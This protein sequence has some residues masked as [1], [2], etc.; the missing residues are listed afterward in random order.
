MAKEDMVYRA[1]IPIV[2]DDFANKSRHKINELVMDF[3]NSDIYV[4]RETGYVNITGKIKDEIKKIQDGSMVLHIVT[5][6]TIPP[7]KDRKPNHWYFVVTKSIDAGSGY[8]INDNYI[9]YGTV[10]NFSIDKNYILFGQNFI[11][12]GSIVKIRVEENYVPCFYVPITYD[13]EYTNIDTEEKLDST[14]QGRVYALQN[15]SYTVYDVYTLDIRT[16]G[17]YN[18]RVSAVENDVYT[19]SF[20]A[21]IAA[22]GVVLPNP[23]RVKAGL[24]LGYIPPAYST[25]PRYNFAGYSRS[26]DT[27]DL[28]DDEFVPESHM[29]LY[30]WYDYIEP[31][32]DM[33]AINF[34]YNSEG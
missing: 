10:N 19:I 3:D 1:K 15:G 28:V 25:D 17:I 22:P 26:K 9:F 32:E 24:S 31:T 16:P 27:M 21:N 7:V 13:T 29:I 5:E 34:T 23:F 11:H 33:V 8:Q 18:I 12:S 14:W 20:M 30:A 4:K 2:P 6:D